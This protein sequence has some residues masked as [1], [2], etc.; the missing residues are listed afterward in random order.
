MDF[1][2]SIY[3]YSTIEF[4]KI[5]NIIILYSDIIKFDLISDKIIIL[6]TQI[7]SSINIIK[8]FLP[9]INKPFIII[10][11][12]DFAPETSSTL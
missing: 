2:N 5:S 11:G 9:H 12:P 10:S 3:Y 7:Q 8:S 1:P 4:S 6:C